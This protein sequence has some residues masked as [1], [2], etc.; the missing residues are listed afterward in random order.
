VGAASNRVLSEWIQPTQRIGKGGEKVRNRILLISLVVVLAL[1]AGLIGCGGEQMPEYTLTI[2][3]TEGGLVTTPGQ[4][5]GSF[6]YYEGEVVNLVAESDEGYRFVNWAGDV[7]TVADVNDATTTI[8]M[9]GDYSIT[10]S[11]GEQEAVTFVDSNLEAVVRGTIGKPTG[12]VYPS[13][14]DGLT[15]LSASHKDIADL[16]G[17]EHCTS[18]IKLYLYDNQVS[19]VSPLANLTILALLYLW[20]NQISDV[21]PLA[22]LGLMELSLDGNQ[23]SDISPLANLTNLTSLGLENNQ[24]SDISPLAN[25]TSLT[26]LGLW[27][28]QISDISPLANLTDLFQLRLGPNQISDISPLTNLTSLTSLDLGDNQISDI[29]PLANLTNLTSLGLWDNQISD[30]SPLANLTDLRNLSMAGN[31][32]SNIS[33]LANLTKLRWLYLWE[34]QITDISPLADLSLMELNLNDNH[35]SDISPLVNNEGLSRGYEVYLQGN[36]LSQQSINEYI[37]QLEARG[38]TVYY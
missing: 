32:I 15:S 28:N 3:S 21:S 13:D 31:Q 38:V 5:T 27:N 12:C 23:I 14:L 29:S 9:N 30:V 10:A 34:N 17:L 25:L 18:L 7:S 26:S 36:P 4:G 33:A 1:S 16:T 22:G 35:I 8:T 6:T 19:D 2:S 37:P 11:F 24:I 20:S